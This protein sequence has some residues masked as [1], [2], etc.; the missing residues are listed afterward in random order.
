[1][2]INKAY[3]EGFAIP[4]FNINNL[5]FAKYILEEAQRLNSPV[6]IA[7]S[8]NAAKF[9][10]GYETVRMLIEGLMTDL[11]I[12]IPVIL[13]LDHAKKYEDC[14]LAYKAGFDSIMFDGSSLSIKENIHLTRIIK[15]R[16]K[17]ILVEAE[18]G[19]I[20]TKDDQSAYLT[21]PTEAKNF[22]KK[23]KVDLL[24]PAVGSVHGLYHG[25][26][27]IDFNLLKIINTNKVPLVI[28][29]GTGLSDNVL[30]TAL[31]NGVVKVNFNT[32][33]QIA[34]HDAIK[35][36][37]K[38]NSKQVDP[39]KIIGATETAIKTLVAHKIKILNSNNKGM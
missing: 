31:K 6:F 21:T 30:K 32:E 12:T 11:E 39:R 26:P 20:G 34:W 35:D 9:M 18:I 25:E 2:L 5:E 36:Y 1:M 13:H 7:V 22:I 8:P 38:K 33:L 29:G 4:S 23:T 14:L 16:F 27:N 37:M 15:T 28:H 19:H 3:Q 24:A 10:G 17:K